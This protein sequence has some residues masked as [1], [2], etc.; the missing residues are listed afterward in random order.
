MESA[1][2][3]LKQKFNGKDA[4]LVATGPSL[5][6]K[7][8]DFLRD[9]P[10]VSANLGVLMFKTWGFDPTASI[11]SDKDV[12]LN[13]LDLYKKF[14]LSNPN[15]IKVLTGRAAQEAPA[16]II[17]SN[18]LFLPNVRD[19][20]EKGFETEPS[21]NGFFR[22]NTVMYN[23]VQ[24]AY[25][26]GVNGANIVGMDLSNNH[27]WGRNGHAFEIQPLIG[28]QRPDFTKRYEAAIKKGL[29]NN[30]EQRK[31][32]EFSFGLARKMYEENGRRL[33]NDSRSS[34]ECLERIDLL[35]KYTKQPN[36]VAV[37]PAKSSSE[38]VPSK[39]VRPLAGKPLFLHVIDTLRQTYSVNQVVLDTDSEKVAE[40][41]GE[42]DVRWLKRPTSLAN[43]TTD[44]NKLFTYE[45]ER[46]NCD[47]LLQVLP[48]APLLSSQSLDG[49][50]YE[51]IKGEEHDS[52]FAVNR[53]THYL[54]KD[55]QP[56]NYNINRIPNS[57]DLEPLTI[58]CMSAYAVQ[59]DV[60]LSKG[61]RFGVS[62]AQFEIPQIET[63]DID[64]EEDFI[65]AEALIRARDLYGKD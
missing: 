50:L 23:A 25:E 43:N 62:P 45:A 22:G 16:E 61:R 41:L 63:I 38:R 36:V 9:F 46:I 11:F 48:T 28:M 7:R 53:R 60:A 33:I 39:N 65:I 19:E 5:A 14:L 57:V 54:W 42:R 40:L 55:G 15:I 17:D 51:V 35:N 29:P 21:R 18:T 6:Y 34:L 44:G 59:R 37:V 31:N 2:N 20:T 4:F 56:L 3:L 1:L 26:L 32:I 52:A 64:N 10:T 47:I 27:D 58:E 8:M 49:L 12:L 30:P 13:N 24:L